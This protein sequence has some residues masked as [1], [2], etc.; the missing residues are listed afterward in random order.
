MGRSRLV[1]EQHAMNASESH[2]LII[3]NEATT[4]TGTAI[5]G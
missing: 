3:T 5:S 1:S 2:I 4:T